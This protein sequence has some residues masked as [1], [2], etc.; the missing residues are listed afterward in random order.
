MHYRHILFSFGLLSDI[1]YLSIVKAFNNPDIK[2]LEIELNK[3]NVHAFVH[4]F[5]TRFNQH[6]YSAPL[7]YSV[8]VHGLD[9][10]GVTSH[11]VWF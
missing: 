6:K 3:D 11:A 2:G 5:L 9:N 10:M 7:I 4:Q 1:G 8:T